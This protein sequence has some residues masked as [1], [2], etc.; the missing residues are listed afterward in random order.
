MTKLAPLVVLALAGLLVG[1]VSG[2][3]EK[4]PQGKELRALVQRYLEADEAERRQIRDDCDRRYAVLDRGE[5]LE[6]LRAEVLDLVMKSGPKLKGAG[7]QYFYD[8]KTKKGRFILK[9][10]PKDT[11]FVALHGGGIGVGDAGNLTGSMGNPD[12]W[13]IFPEVLE[14]TEKGWTTSGTEE[15][16]LELIEAA[17]RSGKVDPNRIYV[18]GHSMGGY[19]SWTFGAHHADLFAGVAAYAGAPSPIWIDEK[20]GTIEAIELGILP[21]YY[22]LRL[23]V[24]QSL[25]DLNVPC[26]A[27]EFAT[28]QLALLKGEY[29]EGFDYRYDRVDGRGHAAPAEGYLPSQKWVA[30]RPRDPRPK[31]FLWQPSLKWKK[32]FFWLYWNDPQPYSIIRGKALEGNVIAIDQI[33]SRV[34]I[35]DF[36]VLLGAPLVDLDHEVTIKIDGEVKFKGMVAARLSTLLL[37]AVRNDPYLLFDS[38]VDL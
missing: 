34:E 8:K 37:T 20:A 25:D 21:N 32:Q 28:K 4:V 38:R 9:G 27:N 5:G 26:Y 15:F 13:W 24:Y 17:K 33:E 23:H 7:N 30:E 18:T 35:A 12:W 1:P 2:Q 11:L 6:K 14:K 19:G 29:P 3:T 10:R 22:N 31:S 16:V 36:S